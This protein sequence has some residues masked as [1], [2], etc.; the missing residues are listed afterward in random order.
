MVG[1]RVIMVAMEGVLT[2]QAKHGPTRASGPSRCLWAADNTINRAMIVLVARYLSGDSKGFNGLIVSTKQAG[3]E[4]ATSLRQNE[5]KWVSFMVK[6]C[7]R[8]WCRLL[9]LKKNKKQHV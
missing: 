3:A 6:L 1:V 4:S 8:N 7:S 9:Y 2:A 5:T